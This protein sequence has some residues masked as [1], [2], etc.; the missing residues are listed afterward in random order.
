MR[1]LASSGKK[2]ATGLVNSKAWKRILFTKKNIPEENM[3]LWVQSE[4]AEQ[5]WSII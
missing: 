4:E 1:K 2:M 5:Y 3:T